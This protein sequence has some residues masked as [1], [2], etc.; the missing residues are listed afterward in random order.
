MLAVY[1]VFLLG[2]GPEIIQNNLYSFVSQPQ[3]INTLFMGLINLNK[4]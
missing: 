2:F 4:S 3:T 1:R